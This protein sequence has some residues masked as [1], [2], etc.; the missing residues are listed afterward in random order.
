MAHASDKMNVDVT[1]L[2]FSTTYTLPAPVDGVAARSDGTVSFPP[3]Q[4]VP[5]PQLAAQFSVPAP[6]HVVVATSRV[7][8]NE[9]DGGLT[10]ILPSG[11]QKMCHMPCGC[12][13][14]AF[15]G[16]ESNAVVVSCD[17]G[18]V[19]VVSITSIGA[20][21]WRPLSLFAEHEHI[22]T[23]VGVC[24]SAPETLASASFDHTVKVWSMGSGD[25]GGCTTSLT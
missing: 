7:F 9:W 4:P 21:G 6:L 5:V 24:P 3:K 11:T 17:D 12:T 8:G 14:V 23:A 15:V 1:E 2:A 20:E 25:E 22:A 16:K 10:A 18:N 13:D 19:I